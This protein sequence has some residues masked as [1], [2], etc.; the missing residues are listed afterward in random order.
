MSVAKCTKILQ[1]RNEFNIFPTYA[2]I[3]TNKIIFFKI[4]PG[5]SLTCHADGMWW[6]CS[7]SYVKKASLCAPAREAPRA[8]HHMIAT[9]LMPGGDCPLSLSNFEILAISLKTVSK[10]N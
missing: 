2:T 7:R 4:F 9:T 8:T 10:P 5:W 6:R 1:A 3:S